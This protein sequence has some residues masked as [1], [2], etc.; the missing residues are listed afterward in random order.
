MIECMLCGKVAHEERAVD[1]TF[2]PVFTPES[3]GYSLGCLCPW[4]VEERVVTDHLASGDSLWI[5]YEEVAR[6]LDLTD[7]ERTRICMLDKR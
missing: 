4:C 3:D 7:E 6:E 1:S 2:R 5:V